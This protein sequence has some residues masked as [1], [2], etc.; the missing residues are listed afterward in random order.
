[1]TDSD[2]YA[3]G[4]VLGA[5]MRDPTLAAGIFARVS[6]EDFDPPYREVAEAI[7]GLR[8]EKAT[9]DGV[10]VVD[11]MTRR[12]TIGR[13]GAAEVVGLVGHIGDPDYGTDVLVRRA[14]LRRL[15]R[16]SVET[17]TWTEMP[18][19]DPLAI[20]ETLR[21]K[22]Q[23]V[24]DGVEAEGDI[25]TLTLG[26]FLSREDPDYAWVIP[27]LLERGDRLILTGSEGLGKALALDT[28]ILTTNGWSDMG[29]I[30]VGSE[31]F[32]PDG[33]PVRVIAATDVMQ[34]R[35]C[36]RLTFSDG[37]Q[38]IA[39]EQHLWLTETV[40]S[41]E[42]DA[43]ARKRGDTKPR[44][45]D[46]R[47]KRAHHPAIVTTGQIADSVR[48]RS[49]NVANHAVPVSSPIQ[50][51]D[52]DLPIAPYVLGAW[53][54]DGTS[55]GSGFTCADQGII[56]EIAKHEPVRTLSGNYSWS[57]SGG[58]A[59]RKR[60]HSLK[61]R[62]SSLDLLQNKHIP[63]AYL[64]ASV[65]QRLELLRG[66]MDTDGSVT[67]TTN[68]HVCEFM[69]TSERLVRGVHELVI[70]LGINASIREGVAKID[71]RDIG[72][73][74]R[75]TFTTD[76]EVFHLQRK[77]DRQVRSTTSRSRYRYITDV[78][79]VESV[80]VRCI[81]VD[82]EDGLFLAGRALITTHNSVLQRQLAVCAAAGVHPFNHSRVPAVRVLYVDCENGPT[83]LRRALRG[84]VDQARRFGDDPSMNMWIE[85][86]PQGLDLTKA[87][88]EM[89]LT[90]TVAALQPD[91][92][93]TGPIY[94]LHAAN[95]N[96]EEPARKVTQVLDR[97]RSAANC[98]I[99]TEAHAGH[100]YGGVE[101]PIRPTGSSLWLRWPEFGYGL[102]ATADFDPS[103]RVVD[104]MPWRGDREERDWPKRIKAG[105]LW[106]WIEDRDSM[107]GAA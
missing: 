5:I 67:A 80:P 52:A 70:S 27:G 53:L 90:R 43:R 68:S 22:A 11:A 56:D 28:P 85:A 75:V 46:Q 100:G 104:F 26:E 39:D 47:H 98:A 31:V 1:M 50:W 73:K 87:E 10:S 36:Y 17:Q 41:R 9:I 45:T 44:G 6:T 2:H 4:V 106:P 94:R 86:I 21:S 105:G 57:I 92:L 7:H 82:R 83:K 24:I 14:R 93:L 81:Q 78:E 59:G 69:G 97:C 18:D 107:V 77:S 95:P 37:S 62:L 49:S 29:S 32:H 76:L 35:P 74:W 8:L 64:Q 79:K 20:A 54:G 96:D 42:A 58:K 34:N 84:L 16:T 102:R 91:L 71:G 51:P 89:W 30:K 40:G 48:V 25:T 72:P 101:R 61:E 60:G 23:G 12:G 65:D 88:D 55:R 19:A 66:L 99:V 3:Q 103:R 38:I 15:W 13:I 63:K 33:S